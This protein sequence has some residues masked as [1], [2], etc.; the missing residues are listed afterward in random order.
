MNER[1]REE[2]EFTACEL[3][4]IHFI[5]IFFNHNRSRMRHQ[6]DGLCSRRGDCGSVN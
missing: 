1:T 6:N 5:L 3:L 2:R 4:H